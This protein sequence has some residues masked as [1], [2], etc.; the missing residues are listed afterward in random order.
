MHVCAEKDQVTRQLTSGPR[1]DFCRVGS[2][3]D[4]VQ[5]LRER[6]PGTTQRRIHVV[7]VVI[8]HVVQVGG[9][10]NT[11]LELGLNLVEFGT[12]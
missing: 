11:H 2:V 10:T 3:N 6:R 5:L 4:V 12:S 8:N 1:D 9:L 7:I